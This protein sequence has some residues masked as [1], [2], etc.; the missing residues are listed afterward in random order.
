MSSLKAAAALIFTK[1]W[2]HKQHKFKAMLGKF[3]EKMWTNKFHDFAEVKL[4]SN[5]LLCR[6]LWGV[7][8]ITSDR[9]NATFV[10]SQLHCASAVYEGLVADESQQV[11]LSLI[12]VWLWLIM[13]HTP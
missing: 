6:Q 7:R 3:N 8:L 1:M 9:K 13:I 10:P 11:Y 2:I 12:S 4:P 5:L